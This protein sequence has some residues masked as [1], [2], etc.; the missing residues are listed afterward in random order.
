MYENEYVDVLV[1]INNGN[2]I[3]EQKPVQKGSKEVVEAK[4]VIIEKLVMDLL[5]Y[6][7]KLIIQ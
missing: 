7:Q 6:T 3:V 4:Q 5:N 2:F 1:G